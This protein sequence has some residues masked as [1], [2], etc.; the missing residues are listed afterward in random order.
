MLNLLQVARFKQHKIAKVITAHWG[1]L[2]QDNPFTGSGELYERTTFFHITRNENGELANFEAI[3]ANLK[4]WEE[5]G[6]LIDR[7]FV[8]T[9]K[10]SRDQIEEICRKIASTFVFSEY[11]HNCQNYVKIC[12]E[13]IGTNCPITPSNECGCISLVKF[14]AEEVSSPESKYIRKPAP[15]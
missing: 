12:L 10:L 3:T 9:T 5:R 2:L 13:A 4:K 15:K 8:S 6:T 14:S 7:T 1:I 11:N